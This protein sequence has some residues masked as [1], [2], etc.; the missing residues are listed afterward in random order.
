MVTHWN[1]TDYV[2]PDGTNYVRE[3]AKEALGGEEAFLDNLLLFLGQIPE[4][5][6]WSGRCNPLEGEQ[7][8][9][10]K[11]YELR[12]TAEDKEF[13]VFGFFAPGYTF[14]MVAGCYHKDK[15]Y[16]PKGAFTSACDRC[17]T[18]NAGI[19]TIVPHT[20]NLDDETEEGDEQIYENIKF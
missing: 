10:R 20:S 5:K 9:K 3:W 16:K 11:L 15:V 4:S 17:D 19:G 7:Y 8:K 18:Y 1:F 14:V 13:R 2:A 6:K 12:F